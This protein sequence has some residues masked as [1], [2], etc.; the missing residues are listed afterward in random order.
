[1]FII[2]YQTIN[3]TNKYSNN[4]LY[5]Q[6]YVRGEGRVKVNVRI[7]NTDN[8]VTFDVKNIWEEITLS[9][10]DVTSEVSTIK[11]SIIIEG[12][13]KVRLSSFSLNVGNKYQRYN[14]IKNGKFQQNK[15]NSLTKWIKK[16]YNRKDNKIRNAMRMQRY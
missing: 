3:Y 10:I 9:E 6:G 4:K 11:V 8:I 13:S 5:L 14:Y 15:E 12:K 7:D 16:Y 2:Y 1:M